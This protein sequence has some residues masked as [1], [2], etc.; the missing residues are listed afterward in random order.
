MSASR[1]WPLGSRRYSVH[2]HVM[3]SVEL[4][5]DP[6]WP[7]PACMIMN[8]VLMRQRSAIR[9]ARTIGSET[10]SRTARNASRD[11]YD[12]ESSPTSARS[13]KSFSPMSLIP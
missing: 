12:S 3:M 7:E 1:L 10:P 2:S 11:T 9:P 8:S 13:E 6:M 4:K 5:L